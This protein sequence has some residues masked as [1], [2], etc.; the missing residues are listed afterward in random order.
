MDDVGFVC[1]SGGLKVGGLNGQV[2]IL[3]TNPSN[4]SMC[5]RLLGDFELASASVPMRLQVIP[6]GVDKVFVFAGV[7]KQTQRALKVW[8]IERGKVTS[9]AN[10]ESWELA[11]NFGKEGKLRGFCRA[12]LV[13]KQGDDFDFRIA[14]GLGIGKAHLWRLKFNE[15]SRVCTQY[16]EGYLMTRRNSISALE[17]LPC[18][19]KLIT[20]TGQDCILQLWNLQDIEK[21]PGVEFFNGS[22]RLGVPV[23]FSDLRLHLGDAGAKFIEALHHEFNVCGQVDFAKDIVSM[24]RW[25]LLFPCATTWSIHD[26]SYQYEGSMNNDGNADGLGI[27]Y[28]DNGNVYRGSWLQGMPNGKG[29]LL[30]E[31][32][33][34]VLYDGFWKNGLKDGIGHEKSQDEEYIGEFFQGA[35]HGFGTMK[36]L[37]RKSMHQFVNSKSLLERES[38]ELFQGFWCENVPHGI[39]R[40][41]FP[42][43]CSSLNAI[44]PDCLVHLGKIGCTVIFKNGSIVRELLYH[45]D[46][47]ENLEDIEL[48]SRGTSKMRNKGCTL[49]L[50][51]RDND[52]SWDDCGVCWV[53][54]KSSNLL[55]C[56]CCS[57]TAHLSC[58]GSCVFDGEVLQKYQVSDSESSFTSVTNKLNADLKVMQVSVDKRKKPISNVDEHQGSVMARRLAKKLCTELVSEQTSILKDQLSSQRSDEI[59]RRKEWSSVMLGKQEIHLQL[60]NSLESSQ[61]ELVVHQL[62]LNRYQGLDLQKLKM[63]DI[64]KFQEKIETA[65]ETCRQVLEAHHTLSI[66]SI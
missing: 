64:T 29:R 50:C 59:K 2:W 49:P 46:D 58:R 45:R 7:L 5:R 32:T 52:G 10:V 57:F 39:G 53:C 43:R 41:L 37:R 34:T 65:L 47:L 24:E 63:V 18:G 1:Q 38:G 66:L 42:A 3:E 9:D 6:I 25:R 11:P 51:L 40:W 26:N 60:Q 4:G 15:S 20:V 61:G 17:F 62:D 54:L 33:G 12:F 56:P 23:N 27:A 35:R 31:S 13:K 30:E 22:S 21:K 8:Y 48:I 36:I 16:Y 28:L 55:K 44:D 19:D 14:C